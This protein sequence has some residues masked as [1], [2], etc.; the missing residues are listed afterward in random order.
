M[1]PLDFARTG[2]R[3][4]PRRRYEPGKAPLRLAHGPWQHGD[5]IGSAPALWDICVG[6]PAEIDSEL[7]AM[8]REWGTYPSARVITPTKP[9]PTAYL[10]PAKLKQG[11]RKLPAKCYPKGRWPR[12][13]QHRRVDHSR[14]S[15]W[16][17]ETSALLWALADHPQVVALI[18][19]AGA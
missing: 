7:E 1:K 8:E 11:P 12:A 19:A 5:A 18:V 10:A 3:G 2:R 9:L 14:H 16:A 13:H 17:G 6:S 15:R 4:P